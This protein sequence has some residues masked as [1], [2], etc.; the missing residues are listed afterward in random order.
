MGGYFIRGG[1][2]G[3]HLGWIFQEEGFLQ[4]CGWSGR[5]VSRIQQGRD[6]QRVRENFWGKMKGDGVRIPPPP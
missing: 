3:I 4:S 5:K 1:L 6:G 2:L